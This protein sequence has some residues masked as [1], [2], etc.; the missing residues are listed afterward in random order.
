MQATEVNICCY[1]LV[2]WDDPNA[3]G[4]NSETAYRE[5][6]LLYKISEAATSLGSALLQ[7]VQDPTSMLYGAT[8]KPAYV[9][10]RYNSN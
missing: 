3:R 6:H 8:W 10:L 9:V 5:G 2:H 4:G 1:S 7:T